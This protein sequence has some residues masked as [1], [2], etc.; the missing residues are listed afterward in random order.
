MSEFQNT[1]PNISDHFGASAVPTMI[2]VAN[3]QYSG[4]RKTDYRDVPKV[5]ELEYVVTEDFARNLHQFNIPLIPTSLVHRYDD[6]MEFKKE[7]DQLIHSYA[8]TLCP[9]MSHVESIMSEISPTSVEPWTFS[10]HLD[11]SYLGNNESNK[12]LTLYPRKNLPRERNDVMVCG[13]RLRGRECRPDDEKQTIH[14]MLGRYAKKV[15]LLHGEEAE[16]AASELYEGFLKGFPNGVNPIS[17]QLL[18]NCV[19]SQVQR[20]AMKREEQEEGDYGSSYKN[21]SRIKF[22]LKGQTKSDLKPESFL[23]GAPTEFGYL[24]KAGQGISAQ[25]KTVNHITGAYMMATE[26]ILRE[27]MDK[28]ILFGHG[29]GKA[30]F[31][32]AVKARL[33]NYSPDDAVMC[34]DIT[35]QDTSKGPWTNIFM[36]R[37]YR[38]VGVPDAVIDV[39]EAPNVKWRIDAKCANLKVEHKFQSGRADTL[40]SNTLMNMALILS[41]VE[42]VDPKL[43]CFEGDDSYLRAESITLVREHE[44]LKISKGGIGDFVGFVMFDDEVGLDLPRFTAKMLNRPFRDD[45]ELSEYRTAVYDWLTIYQD[46]VQLHRSMYANAVKYGVSVEKIIVLFSALRAFYMGRYYETTNTYKNPNAVRGAILKRTI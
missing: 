45:Q 20:I 22:F 30:A 14:T 3:E 23:R 18:S 5:D 37:V 29:L 16:E 39:I 40:L 38:S 33:T 19:A 21:T 35:E 32:A 26:R 15:N 13:A 10:R 2:T 46:P 41:S 17:T 7:K 24:T 9:A 34:A 12:K 42:L 11:Y 25:P 43:M 8:G 4:V 27:A 28:R 1:R 44:N 31:R 6:E 36:R